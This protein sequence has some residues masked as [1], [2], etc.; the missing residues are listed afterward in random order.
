MFVDGSGGG[1]L[2]QVIDEECSAS[3]EV[4]ASDPTVVVAR[5]IF[6]PD[7]EDCLG[8]P[9]FALPS[10]C[11]EFRDFVGFLRLWTVTRSVGRVLIAEC[12]GCRLCARLGQ[13]RGGGKPGAGG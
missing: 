2:E 1:N 11:H 4:V 9:S 8:M 13:G 6:P 7:E 5:V 3:F 10:V 12:I